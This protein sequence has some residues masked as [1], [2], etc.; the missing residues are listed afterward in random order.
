[1]KEVAW[2]RENKLFRTAFIAREEEVDFKN[3]RDISSQS[4][5]VAPNNIFWEERK[6]R[7]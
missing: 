6:L 5:E 1:M 3:F 2:R 7:V 4:I